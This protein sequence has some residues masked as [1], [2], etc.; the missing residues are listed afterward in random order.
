M[1]KKLNKVIRLTL[2]GE[3][4]KLLDIIAWSV[5]HSL[6]FYGHHVLLHTPDPQWKVIIPPE[7]NIRFATCDDIEGLTISGSS[8]Y[9]IAERLAAGDRCL[10]AEKNGRILTLIWGATGP[11]YLWAC[12]T[13]FDAGDDG[14]FYY[15]SHTADEARGLGLSGSLHRLI[16][17]AYAREG[18]CQNWATVSINNTGW[19]GAITTKNYNVVGE[20]YFVKLFF[21]RICYYKS[22]PFPAKKVNVFFKNPPEEYRPV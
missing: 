4:D 19:L 5:P 6:F 15:C 13:T 22:W 7:Y 8:K 16:H 18:R 10:V 21:M 1:I 14:C 3:F 20:T 9:A 17:E 2:R 11:L 12:G